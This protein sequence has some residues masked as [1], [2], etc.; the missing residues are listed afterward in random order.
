MKLTIQSNFKTGL[1]FETND[2][3]LCKKRLQNGC[4]Y[5]LNPLEL[6]GN[7]KNWDEHSKIL[8]FFVQKPKTDQE[9]WRK[10]VLVNN[11]Y[12]AI[13][14]AAGLPLV[15]HLNEFSIATRFFAVLALWGGGP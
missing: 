5:Y 14:D 8:A 10:K 9:F 4:K 12:T 6:G 3:I 11:Y 1:N 7:V 2:K 13:V 15:W